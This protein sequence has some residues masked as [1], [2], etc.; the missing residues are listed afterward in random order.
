MDKIKEPTNANSGGSAE[1]IVAA[2]LMQK[3]WEVFIHCG[4]NSKA[5]L[6]AR[7]ENEVLF[8]EVR[9]PYLRSDGFVAFGNKKGDRCDFYAGVLD[10]RAVYSSATE[11]GKKASRDRMRKWEEP[12]SA[13]RGHKF[14]KT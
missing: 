8:F 4:Q 1:Y 9:K 13:I 12:K 6:V 7:S 2:D 11:Q 5:D 14:K 3:G 10:G